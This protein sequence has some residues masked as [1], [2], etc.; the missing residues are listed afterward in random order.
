MMEKEV[1]DFN[2]GLF[3]WQ[4]LNVILIVL[5]LYF[6]FKLFKWCLRYFGRS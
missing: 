4:V 2:E 3:L 5:V 1:N 6:L